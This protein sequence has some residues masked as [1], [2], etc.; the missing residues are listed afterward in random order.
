M[1][2]V[3][4]IGLGTVGARFV[5]QFGLHPNFTVSG[6][7]DASPAARDRFSQQIPVM[8][9]A[10]EVISACEVVYIAVPPAAHG[11]YV[12]LAV[13]AGV[14]IFCEKPL[15]VDLADS[16]E[17]AALVSESDRGSGVNFVYSSAPAATH[18][19]SL[20][21]AG[22]AG[23]VTRIETRLQFPKWPRSWQREATWLAGAAE[24]GWLREVGSHYL[25]L[26]HRLAAHLGTGPI[27]L[28]RAQS[29]DTLQTLLNI[30]SSPNSHRAAKKFCSRAPAARLAPNRWSSQCLGPRGPFG[31]ESGTALRPVASMSLSGLRFLYLISRVRPWLHIRP[32]STS[33][34]SWHRGADHGLATFDEALAVQKIVEQILQTG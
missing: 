21:A 24:G 14:A 20:I 23:E 1:H 16:T 2:S 19:G 25:F 34:T 17:L 18:L 10:A 15:G 29:S 5:E 27:V 28:Q 13:N 11:T 30:E 31:F 7:W 33:W 26:A 4:I 9:S 8:D 6:A 3:G 32:N 22:D 12:R